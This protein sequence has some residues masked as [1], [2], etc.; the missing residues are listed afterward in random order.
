MPVVRTFIRWCVWWG[1]KTFY[2]Y[3]RPFVWLGIG[4]ADGMGLVLDVFTP[5]GYKTHSQLGREIIREIITRRQDVPGTMPRDPDEQ[6]VLHSFSPSI[7]YE[8]LLRI[9][10][11]WMMGNLDYR[12][13]LTLHED[14][15]KEGTIAHDCMVR[16]RERI[17][18][19]T[20]E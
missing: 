9:K 17:R 5:S 8:E 14:S 7:T 11:Q 10:E 15:I 12:S 2:Y 20:T 19:E 1:E 3:S 18:L 16:A 4:V 13:D 6:T